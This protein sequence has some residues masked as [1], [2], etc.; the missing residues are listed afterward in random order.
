MSKQIKIANQDKV[1]L[2]AVVG[3]KEIGA[4]SLSLMCRKDG[5]L[6]DLGAVP[7]EHAIGQMRLASDYKCT[8]KVDELLRDAENE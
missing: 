8:A 2:Y 1:P 5:A 4:R 6:V 3:E 7:F